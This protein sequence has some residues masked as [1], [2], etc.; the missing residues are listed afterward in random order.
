M[1]QISKEP[2]WT[3][4]FVVM[5]IINALISIGSFMLSA[6]FNPYLNNIGFSASVV[7]M[8]AGISS[9][10]SMVSRVCSG[11]MTN[12]LNKKQLFFIFG[13]FETLSIIALG[14]ITALVPLILMRI[15][16]GF[17]YAVIS[18]AGMTIVAKMLPAGRMNE[19]IGY[20]GLSQIIPICLAPAAGLG[21]AANVGFR[22]MLY[23]SGLSIILGAFLIMPLKIEDSKDDRQ[24][25]NKFKINELVAPEAI[26]PALCAMCFAVLNSMIMNY[27]VMYANDADIAGIA[28]FYIAYGLGTLFIRIFGGK[29]ADRNTFFKNAAVAGVVG[30]LSMLFLWLGRSTACLIFAGTL[31]GL[32][33]GLII[34]VAQS[35]CIS[36]TPPERSGTATATYFLGIDI[37]FVIG[38]TGGGLLIDSIGYANTYGWCI[39]SVLVGVILAFFLV[40][41]IPQ[42]KNL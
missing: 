5:I 32:S 30:I 17:C 31:F 29:F 33:Y 14:Y 26:P 21:L 13:I 23:C 16:Q 25:G 34:P 3:T 15:V 20:Y 2:L 24:T 35:C 10:S 19:G 37:G 36:R 11:G 9:A 27:I 28:W 41:R 1:R 7:G 40:E 42:K 12:R 6:T 22:V 39:A 8:I 18:T 38:S 4:A